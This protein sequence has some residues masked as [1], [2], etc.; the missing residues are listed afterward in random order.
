MVEGKHYP[1]DHLV[2]P[3]RSL[4]VGRSRL[5][6]L[7]FTVAADAQHPFGT[8]NACVF[9]S[10]K[11]YLEPLAIGDAAMAA[12]AVQDGNVFV[13]R[14]Q[15]FLTA[16][17]EGLSAIVALTDDAEA[18]HQAFQAADL[19]GGRVLNFGRVMRLADGREVEASFR[20]AFSTHSQAEE[21]LLFTCQRINPLPADRGS[22]EAHA[23]AV[24][25]IKRIELQAADP[26][27]YVEWFRL[28]F[29][30]TAHATADGATA[31]EPMADG[32]VFETAN[33]PIHLAPRGR[34]G[35]EATA[36]VLA[37]SDLEVTAEVLAANGVRYEREPHGLSVSPQPGQGLRFVFEEK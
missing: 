9:F 22:L 35:P 16:K 21:L 3:V 34:A 27:A 7:G 33:L 37:V 14:D 20:L 25:G 24:T 19:S 6:Q 10:D 12:A 17:G 31:D 11:T 30:A 8:A 23:N 36:L 28:V 2:L 15:A 4:S 5:S 32:V 18:D 13:A 26:Q 29:G 1:V